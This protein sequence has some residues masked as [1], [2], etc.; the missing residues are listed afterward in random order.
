MEYIKDELHIQ[1]YFD[2]PRCVSATSNEGDTLRVTFYEQ[3]IFA[4]TMGNLIS[5][6]ASTEK[7]I[8]R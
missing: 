3:A 2:D 6:R 8:M 1:F 4:D 5:P 7:R